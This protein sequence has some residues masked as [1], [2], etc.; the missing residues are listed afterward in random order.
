[1]R[2]PDPKIG[3]PLNF[4]TAAVFVLTCLL[5]LGAPHASASCT[6]NATQSYISY[7]TS[8]VGTATYTDWPFIPTLC[9]SGY[10]NGG[11]VGSPV[12]LYF[13]TTCNQGGIAIYETI[14]MNVFYGQNSFSQSSGSGLNYEYQELGSSGGNC[15]WTA[16]DPTTSTA[17]PSLGNTSALLVVAPSGNSYDITWYNYAKGVYL[18]VSGVATPARSGIDSTVEAEVL[19][20][21]NAAVIY[22][23]GPQYVTLPNYNLVYFPSSAT[24]GN[25]ANWYMT[26][27]NSF[28]ND[29]CMY[30][31]GYSSY[32]GGL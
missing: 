15:A 21:T 29:Y 9:G 7:A 12:G 8:T 22:D 10:S 17:Y 20:P 27:P 5:A 30:Y 28:Y 16:T 26:D 23:Q 31:T 24:T 13:S 1:M 32:C 19:S 6:L 14:E 2:L 18:Q 3:L 25:M 4:L 11:Y